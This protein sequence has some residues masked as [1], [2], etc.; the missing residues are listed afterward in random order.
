M[1]GT[2][3]DNLVLGAAIGYTNDQT[4]VF[5]ASLK[6]TGYAG[7]VA[8]FVGRDAGGFEDHGLDIE[9][10]PAPHLDPKLA[11]LS[12]TAHRFFMFQHLLARRSV[13]GRILMSD[14]RDVVFQRDPFDF[15]LLPHF[16]LF[17]A[18]EERIIAQCGMNA[19][20][21]RQRYGNGVLRR[22]RGEIISCC[23]TVIGSHRGMLTYLSRLCEHMVGGPVFYG[24]DQGI[25]NYMIRQ[26]PVENQCALLNG[27]GPV[28]TMHYMNKERLGFSET[29][30]ILNHDGSVPNIV[31]QY[32]R[33]PEPMQAR[34][35]TLQ[36]ARSRVSDIVS[37]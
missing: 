20:W 22:L 17:Y 7:K 33:L 12:P 4:R 5:L 3:R 32:D 18:L 35:S 24:I 23:G 27:L 29:G 28:M 15:P 13:S 34:L 9:F 31:H 16:D 25:H 1:A 6:A 8:I 2:D 10:I 19:S 30:E 11:A 21:I 26:D 14:M 36:A 37:C